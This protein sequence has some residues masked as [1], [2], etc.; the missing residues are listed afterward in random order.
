MSILGL[1]S[2]RRQTFVAGAMLTTALVTGAGVAPATAQTLE[3]ALVQAYSGNPTLGAARA[4]LRSVDEGVPAARAG[5]RPSPSLVGSA[6][7]A[8]TQSNLFAPT[9]PSDQLARTTP[10]SVGL[11]VTQ[12]IYQG[13]QIEARINEAENTVLAQRAAL[14]DAEQTVLLQAATAYLDVVQDQALLDLQVNYETFQKRDLE[15]IRDRFRVGEVTQTDVSLQEAQVASATAARIAADGVLSA[16]RATYT[17]LIGSPPGKLVLPKLKYPLPANLDET[18]ALARAHNPTVV[19]AIHTESA[20]RDAVDVADGALLPTVSVIASV[21]RNLDRE[22]PNDFTNG[23]SIIANVTIP[24]DNGGAA[25]KARAARQSASSARITIDQALRAAEEAAVTDWQNLVT[26]R[27]SIASFEAAVKANALAAEG[28]RQQVSVGASTIID[29]LN[30][31]QTLLNSRVNLVKAHHDDSVA[32]FAV[33]SAVG[34]LT[35]Q[36][37]QLPTPYYDYKAH[38][39]AVRD[40]WFG[41]GIDQQ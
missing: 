2:R 16:V 38:Y 31:E 1:M 8:W 21:S 3:E 22:V 10:R 26:A 30:T 18:V 19:T 17:K 35:A 40:K 39:D 25:A 11:S 41:T 23:G 33:L 34:Q 27:A 15:A 14:L 9:I 29:L 6:G 32:V 5:E 13:G 20:A 4:T 37:L 24:L 28:M 36:A 12:P 7:P